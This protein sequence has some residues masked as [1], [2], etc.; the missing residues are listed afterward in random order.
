VSNAAD[1][2]DAAAHDVDRRIFEATIKPTITPEVIA[3]HAGN[4]AGPGHSPELEILLRYLRRNPVRSVPRYV[5]VETLPYR[6]WVIALHSRR[7]GDPPVLT[8]ARFT[9]FEKAQHAIFLRRLLDL[10]DP[11]VTRIVQSI[12]G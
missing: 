7:R 3:E 10:G 6:E 8:E 2:T 12:A 5:L 4:V 1:K 11:D 9:D